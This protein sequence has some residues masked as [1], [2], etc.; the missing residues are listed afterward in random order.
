MAWTLTSGSSLSLRG[1]LSTTLSA[2]AEPT[3][4]CLSYLDAISF[5][6][7]LLPNS[8]G[9]KGV[10]LLLPGGWMCLKKVLLRTSSFA[11]VLSLFIV[12]LLLP[13]WSC[14]AL[15]YSSIVPPSVCSAYRWPGEGV[16]IG[17]QPCK[18]TALQWEEER[19]ELLNW[20]R[21]LGCSSPFCSVSTDLTLELSRTVLPASEPWVPWVLTLL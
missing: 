5:P 21:V 4:V 3:V 18:P 2:F 13:C 15:L 8:E 11:F 19:K 1:I 10:P 12:L 16:V 14:Q 9:S 7:C 20:G 6:S 17:A